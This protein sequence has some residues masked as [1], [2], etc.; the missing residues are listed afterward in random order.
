MKA[1]YAVFW[2]S[3][4]RNIYGDDSHYVLGECMGIYDTMEEAKDLI[5]K[6]NATIGNLLTIVEVYR[7]S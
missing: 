2:L 6:L 4:V 7:K 3:Q 1:E 5:D